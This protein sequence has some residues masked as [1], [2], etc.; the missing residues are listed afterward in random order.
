MDNWSDQLTTG[1]FM[2]ISPFSAVERNVLS[3]K[4]AAQ[5]LTLIKDRHLPP[6]AKLPAERELAAMLQVSR[7][8]LREALRALAIIGA[9]EIRQGDGTYVTSL[10]PDLLV[11][12]IDYVVALNQTTFEELFEARKT[13]EICIAE[14]AAKRITDE[15]I[16]KLENCLSRSQ[17]IGDDY[18]RFLQLDLEFHELIV[19][20]A[21]N[22]I[23]QSPYM[24]S[25]RRLGR[26]SRIHR[27]PVPG[28]PEQSFVQHRR[29]LDALKTRDPEST[30][31]AMQDHLNYIEERLR[32]LPAQELPLTPSRNGPT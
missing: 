16:A 2:A 24:A 23:F 12:H 19:K 13:L 9:V 6:G 1:L 17:E 20:A 7:P 4:I 14:V 29:I 31:Q 8:S 32:S 18:A 26:V 3:E 10:E 30:R 5:I 25:I 11:D 22:P 21:R 15:D 27:A 28:V